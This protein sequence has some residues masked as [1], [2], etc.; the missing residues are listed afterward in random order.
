MCLLK[1]NVALKHDLRLP[2]AIKHEFYKAKKV[3]LCNLPPPPKKKKNVSQYLNSL[4]EL[5][6]TCADPKSAKNTL[7]T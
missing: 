4:V 3:K 1:P 2:K 7:T 5:T 6:F